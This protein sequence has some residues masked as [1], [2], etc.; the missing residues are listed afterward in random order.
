MLLNM[1]WFLKQAFLLMAVNSASGL[2]TPNPKVA[3]V[4]RP[5][6][7]YQ[8]MFDESFEPQINGPFAAGSK[9]CFIPGGPSGLIDSLVAKG[10]PLRNIVLAD[11]LY[12][13]SVE[14]LKTEID[15]NMFFQEGGEPNWE[16]FEHFYARK[17]TKG[18]RAKIVRYLASGTVSDLAEKWQRGM[19]KFLEEYEAYPDNFREADIT[20]LSTL[21]EQFD[22]IISTN[23]LH[24]YKA[25]FS[26]EFHMQAYEN[27]LERLAPGGRLLVY[28]I[29]VEDKAFIEQYLKPWLEDKTDFE[30]Q[31][32]RSGLESD[33]NALLKQIE[34]RPET[35]YL[36]ISR[37]IESR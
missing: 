33:V 18:D 36:Q 16:D 23:L 32:K 1:T 3:F 11:I 5:L 15:K 30:L 24:L 28:P 7:I 26:A 34:N 20:N 6:E 37:K 9:I 17:F 13:R 29:E 22:L 27:L 31:L 2:A 21:D 25:S 12:G 10:R 35:Q 4:G 19:A 8:E 14:E